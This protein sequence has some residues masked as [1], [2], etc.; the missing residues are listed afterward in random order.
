MIIPDWSR[1]MASREELLQSIHPGM[2]INKAFFLKVYGYEV[3]WPRFRETAIKALEDAGCSK[4]RKYY[5]S[6]VGEYEKGHQKQMKE[7]GK[8][9][10]EECEKKGR[11]ER[12][13]REEIELLARKKRLLMQKSQILTKD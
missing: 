9:Y 4:A 12:R 8:W 7:V 5:D 2:V 11:E 10:L 6:V 1:A 3:T 13:R